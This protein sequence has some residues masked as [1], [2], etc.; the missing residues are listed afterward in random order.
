MTIKINLEIEVDVI[1]NYIKASS[2]SYEQPPEPAEFEILHVLWQGN[3]ITSSLNKENFEWN[4]LE[5]QCI[6]E[7]ENG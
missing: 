3:A 5:N 4:D 6:E 1:G 2:G 7:I